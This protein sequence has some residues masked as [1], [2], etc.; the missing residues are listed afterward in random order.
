MQIL[1]CLLLV[2]INGFLLGQPPEVPDLRERK[3]GTD[4]PRFLGPTADGKSTETGLLES[5]PEN[6]PPIVWSFESGSGYSMPSIALGRLFYFDRVD[7]RA[8][9]TCMKSETGEILWQK[10]YPTEY[11]DMLDFS[12]GPRTS[13]VIEDNR[14]YYYGVEGRLRCHDVRDGSLIWEVDTAKEFNVVQNFFGVGSTPIIEN[15]YLLTMVGGS[16][17]NSPS[18][19][20]GEVK[21]NGTCIVAFDKYTGEVRYS[22]SDELASYATIALATINDRRWGFAFARGGLVGFDPNKGTLDFHYPWRSHRQGAANAATPLVIGDR[23]LIT[24]AYGIGASYLK[25]KP[26]GYELLWKDKR[27]RNRI[28]ASHWCTP[29]YHEGFVYGVSGPNENDSELRCFEPESGRIKW[30]QGR[31]RRMTLLYAEGK[32]IALGERGTLRLIEAT[33][34]R[35]NPISEFKPQIDGKD[36]LSHP[37]FNPPILSHG[38]LYVRGKNRL[39]CLDIRKP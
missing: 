35:Y 15:D 30:R 11:E 7:N 3:S 23:V 28:L 22:I 20:S 6:G 4:W 29:I 8:R 31:L 16:P 33:P 24:E 21:G 32:F 26:G 19:T 37:A 2:G 18:V 25:V 1:L 5:W 14:V 34:D 9:L 36:A 10:D 13:P 39:L 12:D 38:Y 27:S 17:P